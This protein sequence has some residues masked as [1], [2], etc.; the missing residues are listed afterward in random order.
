MNNREY[1]I[2]K[3]SNY[4]KKNNT[5]GV[6]ILIALDDLKKAN[7]KI[8]YLEVDKFLLNF[9]NICKTTT[10]DIDNSIIARMNG[11]EFCIFLPEYSNKKAL[12]IAKKIQ[13]ETELLIKEFNIDNL[14]NIFIGLYSYTKKENPSTLLAYSDEALTK[15]QLSIDGIYHKSLHSTDEIMSI[16]EWEKMINKAI[17]SNS[18]YFI[19]FKAVDV[20]NKKILHNRLSLSLK[21]EDNTIYRYNQFMPIVYKLNLVE[22][23]YDNILE[24]MFKTPDET[25]KEFICSLRLPYEYLILKNSYTKIQN[26]LDKYNNNLPFSLSIEISDKF[27]S[28]HIEETIKYKSMFNKHNIQIGL[29]DFEY[30]NIEYIKKLKP[31]YIKSDANY[32]L[33]IDLSKLSFIKENINTKL[34]A[35]NVKNKQL[36]EK[37]EDREIYLIQGSVT[38]YL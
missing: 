37:L 36:L 34:I 38:Q 8:G 26:I 5:F 11:S 20:E 25:L 18:F 14:V 35:T 7:K 13:L 6:N 22:E 17:S 10:Q 2:E 24:M 15:A 9:I 12:S 21:S 19:S 23:F 27:A 30:T 31:V 29:Y 32:L 3:L 1:F 4:F 28:K 16:K 33:S